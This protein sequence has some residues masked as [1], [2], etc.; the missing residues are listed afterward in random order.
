MVVGVDE[1]GH[2]CILNGV[3]ARG[4]MK[5][6]HIIFAVGEFGKREDTKILANIRLISKSAYD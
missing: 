2:K 4:G 3:G 1:V 5:V 6:A